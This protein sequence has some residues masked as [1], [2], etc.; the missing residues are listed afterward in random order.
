M[1]CDAGT[2]Y[3]MC[4]YFGTPFKWFVLSL[5]ASSHDEEAWSEVLPEFHESY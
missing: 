2:A 3:N 1:I 4:K 5:S